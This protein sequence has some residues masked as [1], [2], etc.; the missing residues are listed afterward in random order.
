MK[1]N[2]SLSVLFHILFLASTLANA[3]Q[4]NNPAPTWQV[5]F[6]PRGGATAAIVQTLNNARFSVLVQAY[7]FTSTPIAK[8]LVQAHQHG[9]KVL[10]LLD[11]SQKAYKS[12]TANFLAGA[13]IAVFIDDVHVI[14]HN[15]VIIIDNESVITGSFDFGKSAEERNAEDLLIIR[16]SWLQNFSRTGV[17]TKDTP[18]CILSRG[19]QNDEADPFPIGFVVSTFDRHFRLMRSAGSWNFKRTLIAGRSPVPG[20]LASL[21]SLRRIAEHESGPPTGFGNYCS[22][23]DDLFTIVCEYPLSREG[24]P[25]RRI[26][27]KRFAGE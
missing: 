23:G 22:S 19:R 8:A 25:S 2:R 7:S 5:Y 24:N 3:Q 27:L 17:F 12:S 20:A 4:T 11:K 14:A 26:L 13:G 1:T 18:R 6:S 15:K 16:S 10:V 9:V 21:L